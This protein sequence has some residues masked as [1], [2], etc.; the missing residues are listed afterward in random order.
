MGIRLVNILPAFMDPKKKMA[1]FCVVAPCSLVEVCR[2][3]RGTCCLSHLPDDK[4]S[5]YLWNVRKLLPDYTALQP[6]WLPSLCS[7]PWDPQIEHCLDPVCSIPHLC[8]RFQV[9][10]TQV[11]SIHPQPP[12]IITQFFSVQLGSWLALWWMFSNRTKNGGGRSPLLGMNFNICRWR[13]CLWIERSKSETLRVTG[14]L[15]IV[16]V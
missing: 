4:G 6:R 14:F 15:K 3:L 1:V 7:P 13:R 10:C 9:V 8:I 11:V 2:R 16:C 12:E 5:K